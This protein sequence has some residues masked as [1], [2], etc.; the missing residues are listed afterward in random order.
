MVM[1]KKDSTV[2]EGDTKTCRACGATKPIRQFRLRSDKKARRPD[3]QRCLIKRES[4]APAFQK[5]QLKW[6]LKNKYGITV[7]EFEEMLAEQRGVCAICGGLPK[8]HSRLFVDHCHRSGAVRGLLCNTCNAGLG[9]FGDR[10]DLLIS[11]LE[12]LLQRGVD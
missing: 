12:Y 11:A 10:V 4:Q 8:V 1:G 5:A 7:Q 6:V 3:C 2:A 9:Q